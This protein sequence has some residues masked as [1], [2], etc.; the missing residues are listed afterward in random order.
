MNNKSLMSAVAHGAAGI[1]DHLM[2]MLTFH[3]KS[4][5]DDGHVRGPKSRTLLSNTIIYYWHQPHVWHRNAPWHPSQAITVHYPHVFLG[6]KHINHSLV[7]G[8]I[9][10]YIAQRKQGMFPQIWKLVF[11]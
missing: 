4:H 11:S 9:V 3:S 1:H 8:I 5:P 7:L 10:E 2:I 6:S